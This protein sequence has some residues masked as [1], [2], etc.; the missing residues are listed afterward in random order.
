MKKEFIVICPNCDEPIII[1]K[2]RCGVFRHGVYK[3]NNKNIH[4][5]T[6]KK[7]CDE[8]VRKKM[9]YGCGKPFQVIILQNEIGVIGEDESSTTTNELRSSFLVSICD[10][11]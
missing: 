2:I 1:E 10:Y 7:K 6:N 3:K 4:P 9:I 8:L 11:I 5:H